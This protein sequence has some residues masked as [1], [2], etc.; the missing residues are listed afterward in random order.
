MKATRHQLET[1]HPYTRDFYDRRRYVARAVFSYIAENGDEYR[2]SYT[3]IPYTDERCF[4]AL[5]AK[6]IN[7]EVNKLKTN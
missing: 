6:E 1:Y 2:R 3:W 4:W 5:S 7:I